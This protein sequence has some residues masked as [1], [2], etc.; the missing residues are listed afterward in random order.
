M[1]DKVAR[2]RHEREA[3]IPEG[4]GCMPTVSVRKAETGSLFW[5][6][7]LMVAWVT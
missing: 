2:E 7:R 4:H 6:R 3:K 1:K 5:P